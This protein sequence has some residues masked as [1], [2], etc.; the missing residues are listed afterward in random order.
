M[1]ELVCIFI[2]NMQGILGSCYAGHP[3]AQRYFVAS[4]NCIFPGCSPPWMVDVQ[5]HFGFHISSGHSA[6]FLDGS[7]HWWKY[8]Y[9]RAQGDKEIVHKEMAY[10]GHNLCIPIRLHYVSRI[11]FQWLS[12]LRPAS[13]SGSSTLSSRQTIKSSST[14]PSCEVFT[15]FVKMGRG[16]NKYLQ[17]S[18]LITYLS[19]TIA[20]CLTRFPY[21]DRSSKRH[22]LWR[23]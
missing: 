3:D 12:W 13:I 20:L 19:E 11:P 21:F 10:V 5:L 14:L 6:Q 9:P 23:P 7:Y 2:K 16:T 17:Y 18:I 15:L 1:R 4:G 22:D 8:R